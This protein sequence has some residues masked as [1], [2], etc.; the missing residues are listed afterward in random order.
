M[1]RSHHRGNSKALTALAA[2]VICMALTTAGLAGAGAEEQ[3]S[4]SVKA[5]Q[6]KRVESVV[7]QPDRV[8]VAADR[9]TEVH[10]QRGAG[11]V[12]TLQVPAS[13]P[14]DSAPPSAT[15]S[16]D[17]RRRRSPMAYCAG[18]GCLDDVR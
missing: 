8:K 10:Q 11:S 5:Y 18:A 17:K 2:F 9:N 7:R 15:S 12:S 16:I 3:R 6:S 4:T 14:V 13:K 1:R